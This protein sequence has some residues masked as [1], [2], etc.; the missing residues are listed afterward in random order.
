MD[1]PNNLL[2]SVLRQD[3]KSFINKVFNTINPGTKYQSNW[4]IELIADYLEAVRKKEINRLIINLPPRGLKSICVS[5]AW[6]AWLL[7]HDPATRI[8]AASYSNVLSL[9]HSLDCKLAV[10][11]NWYK[12]IFPKTVLSKRH[13]QKSKFL[14]SLNG[15]R[16]ATSVGGSTTGEGGDFLIVD[17][18]HNPIHINSLIQR[19][20]VIEWFE[21]TFLTRLNNKNEGAVIIVM[22]RLHE[23]DLAGYLISKSS[24]WHHLRIPI[25]ANK[26]LKF[27]ISS[28]EYILKAGEL[29]HKSIDHHETLVQL[30]KEIGSH[31]YNAQYLQEPLP[32]GCSLLKMEDISF[33]EELPQQFDYFVQSWDTAIKISEKADYSVFTFFG[34]KDKK[35]YLISMIRAKYTYPDL[36]KEVIKLAQKYN[37][38]FILIEDKAS[39]QQIIQDLKLENFNNIIPIRPKIDKI[40]RFASVLNLFQ[41]GLILLPK[42]ANYKTI[43]LKE[44]TTFPYS[45]H[46]DIIDSI[47][48]FLNFIKTS[49]S[50]PEVRIRVI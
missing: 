30:E 7:G 17:D 3:F 14:T 37:P 6:P 23:E 27:S 20:K 38:K 35:Y 9:K 24:Y 19:N 49:T 47:S 32:S 12:Q 5:V 40:T 25:I 18:P 16:F 13:N 36:K 31:N 11:S 34:I 29:L 42:N 50:R 46:D 2:H 39:G 44:L 28:K 10:S 26:D 22:Q 1:Y 21:Q 45:P 33:Y 4:H 48:Q 41:A 8:I 15:F 43:L